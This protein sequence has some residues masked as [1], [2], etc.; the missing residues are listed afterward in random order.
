MEKKKISNLALVNL[1]FIKIKIDN[2]FSLKRDMEKRKKEIDSESQ[3]LMSL[4]NNDKIKYIKRRNNI[5]H[6]FPKRLRK[7][8][9]IQRQYDNSISTKDKKEI[10]MNKSK[11][12]KD[13]INNNMDKIFRSNYFSLGGKFI[14]K[15][16]GE[17]NIFI[18]SNTYNSSKIKFRFNSTH[19]ESMDNLDYS[20]NKTEN[21]MNNNSMNN[22]FLT[23]N[24]N[25]NTSENDEFQ[26]S[27]KNRKEKMSKLCLLL[28]DTKDISEDIKAKLKMFDKTSRNYN[29]KIVK[30]LKKVMHIKKKLEKE[31]NIINLKELFPPKNDNEL[32]D[33]NLDVNKN[34]QINK[35]ALF[36]QNSTA[37]LIK[38]AHSLLLMPDDHVYRER[39]RLIKEYTLLENHYLY[40]RSYENIKDSKIN[41]KNF[42]K[43]S[44]RIDFLAKDIVFLF[45]KILNRDA[46]L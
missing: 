35:N 7:Y 23:N 25:Y 34:K 16:K 15:R 1:P 21:K 37:N 31:E 11:S 43:R 28:Q 44:K 22:I 32:N 5:E 9:I 13:I 33:L 41:F 20:S 2:K 19:N 14:N 17:E 26:S 39:K 30:K 12:N 4:C 10:V 29:P 24:Y 46:K 38:Y 3:K 6:L 36:L 8:S 18:T 27:L 45:H 42:R 40:Y